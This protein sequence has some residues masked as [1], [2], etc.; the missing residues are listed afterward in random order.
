MLIRREIRL[1]D[2]SRRN[3]GM[4]EIEANPPDGVGLN[5]SGSVPPLYILAAHLTTTFERTQRYKSG[6]PTIRI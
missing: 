4:A 5:T 1:D 6:T 2:L 3:E